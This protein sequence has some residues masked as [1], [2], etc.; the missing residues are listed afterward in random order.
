MTPSWRREGFVIAPVGVSK[1]SFHGDPLMVSLPQRAVVDSALQR[2]QAALLDKQHGQ[3]LLG[4]GAAGDSILES[5]YLLLRFILGQEYDPDLPLI[6]N[7]L[8][9]LQQADGGWSL[10]PGGPPDFRERSKRTSH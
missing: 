9:S 3:G 10:F 1:V 8:R 5:E 2:A 4:W 7:Y 6:A